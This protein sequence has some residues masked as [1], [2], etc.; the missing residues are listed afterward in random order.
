MLVVGA[1]PGLVVRRVQASR[2]AAN[3]NPLTG[4]KECQ[5]VKRKSK[6]PFREIHTCEKSLTLPAG[7][8]MGKD[9]VLSGLTAE[10]E[11]H[12]NYIL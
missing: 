3:F 2:D 10:M 5:M 6:V 4:E 8:T 1:W 11:N 7:L 12:L 9:C